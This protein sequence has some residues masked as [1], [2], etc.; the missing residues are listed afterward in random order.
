MNTNSL[1]STR[2]ILTLA[3]AAVVGFVGSSVANAAVRP[4]G[5]TELAQAIGGCECCNESMPNA[6]VCDCGSWGP[7]PP[8]ICAEQSD[9]WGNCCFCV[10]PGSQCA[11]SKID[12]P[13]VDDVCSGSSTPGE[14]CSTESGYCCKFKI[15]KCT[16]LTFPRACPC[17]PTSTT[18]TGGTRNVCSPGSDDC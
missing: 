18:R 12:G 5:E 16:Q 14:E 8:Q 11:E 6:V 9:I 10:N 13:D 17:Y 7:T 3:S 2:T 4:L 1:T 15:Y